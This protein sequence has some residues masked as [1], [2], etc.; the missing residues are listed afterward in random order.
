LLGSDRVLAIKSATPGRLLMLRPS[1][2]V[3]QLG[4]IIGL[5]ATAQAADIGHGSNSHVAGTLLP[6]RLGGSAA[7]Q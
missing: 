3:A 2:I 5:A 6:H 7:G 4:V 1:R